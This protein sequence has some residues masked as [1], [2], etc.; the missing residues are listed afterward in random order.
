MG[1]AEG[2]WAELVEEND[3]IKIMEL[4]Y[5]WLG[6]LATCFC[7]QL[8]SVASTDNNDGLQQPLHPSRADVQTILEEQANAVQS[9]ANTNNAAA[10]DETVNDAHDHITQ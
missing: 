7:W 8:C 1:Y 2:S 10:V 4:V 5:L 6:L 3:G 9:T